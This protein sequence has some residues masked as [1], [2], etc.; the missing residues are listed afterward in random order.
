MVHKKNWLSLLFCAVFILQIFQIIFFQKALI[1][2]KYDISYWKDRFFHS[3]WV[4]PLSKRSIGDDGLYSY[5]GYTLIKDGKLDGYNVEAPPLAKYF[6]G[7]SIE[8][9]DNPL[10]VSFGFG[11][12]VLLFLFFIG[13]KVL[14]SSW[15]SFYFVVL[16]FLDK[17]FFS[18]LSETLLDVPQLFFLLVN[19][20]FFLVSLERKEKIFP[21]L[22]GISLGFFAV[23][24][25]PLFVPL[26]F[27]MEVFILFHKK[28]FNGIL[29][30]VS[31][32]VLGILVCYVPYFI[33]GHSLVDFLKLEKYV[34]S[35]YL[36]SKLQPNILSVWKTI[37][38]GTIP[39]IGGGGYTK[40]LEWSV[41]LPI[42]FLSTLIFFIKHY[43]RKHVFGI[44]D[45]LGIFILL[46]LVLFMKIPFSPRYIIIILPVF[47]LLSIKLLESLKN[48]VIKNGIYVLVLL[49][50]FSSAFLFLSPKP[51]TVLSDFSYNISHFYFKD[52][53]QED[54]SQPNK[55]S[56]DNFD[57][58]SKN[59]FNNATIRSLVV[60]ETGR[61]V[62]LS[63][64]NGWVDY[65][66]TYSTQNLGQFSE[67][68]RIY[69][70]KVNQEWKINWQWIVLLNEYNLTD[71]VQNNVILGGR[72]SIL[73]SSGKILA[74]DG[75]GYLI[76]FD[77][78]KLDQ[79][80]EDEM[81]KV[82]SG[83][84]LKIPVYLQNAYL[85]NPLDSSN[86]LLTTTFKKLSDKDLQKLNS[87]SGI[88][89]IPY[90]SRVYNGID[91]QSIG[92]TA[93][94]ECCTSIY[95]PYSYHGVDGV[96]EQFDAK[97]SGYD[98]GSLTLFD[99]KGKVKRVIIQKTPKNGED[100]TVN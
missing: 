62:P 40:I 34:V 5:I 66:F 81:L 100:V 80:K 3:Q 36:K 43:S 53:Y 42:T 99:S 96:E 51:D 18:Q 73:D 70:T 93:Y 10:F 75:M 72:G 2:R 16:I 94:N 87:Y 47:Y 83:Y 55:I 56:R 6:Y 97:L 48:S 30:Y 52:I 41:I 77:V 45:S 12:G 25:I 38:L 76:S 58:I 71:K 84:S 35:F 31:F 20:Y 79:K 26:V 98:G 8:V 17:L 91:P 74:G 60:K 90:L 27:L 13:K 11:I 59:L 4:L 89:V 7:Y 82:I 15:A 86:V 95:S 78:S 19:F 49:Y 28:K 29:F 85:E 24:K 44:Q 22:S 54:I 39:N 1:F 63:G 67:S 37:F 23:T 92:N 64:N 69:L 46:S 65:I 21:I 14:K 9:F 32:F 57:S 50:S 33:A 68:K 61:N 88:T